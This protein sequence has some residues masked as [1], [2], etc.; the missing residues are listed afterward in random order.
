MKK[1]I[2]IAA[3][4]L[5]GTSSLTM[6]QNL[7]A[8]DACWQNYG[9]GQ[10]RTATG[11]TRCTIKAEA[12]LRINAPYLDLFALLDSQRLA[13]AKKIDRKTITLTEGVAQMRAANAGVNSE[14]QR[15]NLMRQASQPAARPMTFCNQY[16][17]MTVCN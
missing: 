5:L 2:W 12:P 6:A 4:I 11:W 14:V 8:V 13:I 16:G 15:R 1:T 10:I 17:T 9:N 3:S 7:P